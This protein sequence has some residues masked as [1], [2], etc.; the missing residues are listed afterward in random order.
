MK[1]ILPILLCML[2]ALSACSKREISTNEEKI[3]EEAVI[4]PTPD[5][6]IPTKEPT[7]PTEEPTSPTAISILTDI[8]NN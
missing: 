3:E 4:A 6:I 8:Y 1:K 7:T 2:L 5:P